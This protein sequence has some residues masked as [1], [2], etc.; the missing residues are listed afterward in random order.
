M[1]PSGPDVLL[2][3]AGIFCEIAL[4]VFLF[5]ISRFYEAKFGQ[6]TR[7]WAFL[8]PPAVYLVLVVAVFLGI[9]E[10]ILAGVVVNLATFLVLVVFGNGLYRKMTGVA[11]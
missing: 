1:N 6:R 4:L 2:L 10:I 5:L 7:S 8:L 3:T 11:R 9:V